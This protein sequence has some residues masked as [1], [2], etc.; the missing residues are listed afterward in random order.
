M[1]PF[2]QET[3]Q[4][5][6]I[7]EARNSSS[8]QTQKGTLSMEAFLSINISVAAEINSPACSRQ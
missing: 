8:E 5:I 4:N 3:S 7:K 6:S 1:P 2:V